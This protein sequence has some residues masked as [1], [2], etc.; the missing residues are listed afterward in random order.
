MGLGMLIA[1]FISN[2]PEAIAGTSGLVAGGWGKLKILLLWLLIA[3]VCAFSSMAGYNLLS[4]AS[5]LTISFIQTFA[6]G[7]ILVMLTNTMIP[8]SFQHGGKQ[9]G[10]FTILGF[11]VAVSVAVYEASVCEHIFSGIL[12]ID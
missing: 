9:A 7:A 12:N 8:E 3:A 4:S 1:V 2:L 10:I 11:A 5:P 6:A